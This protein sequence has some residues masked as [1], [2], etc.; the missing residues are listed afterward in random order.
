MNETRRRNVAGF[1]V[2]LLETNKMDSINFNSF[3]NLIKKKQSIENYNVVIDPYDI[4]Y[5]DAFT[6]LEIINCHFTGS[7]L[8]IKSEAGHSV[9]KLSLRNSFFE[10]ISFYDVEINNL[11]LYNLKASYIN[12]NS[13]TFKN[14]HVLNVQ[15]IDYDL[16][17]NNVKT[18]NNTEIQGCSFAKNGRLYIFKSDLNYCNFTENI[19]NDIFFEFSTFQ[20]RFDFYKNTLNR[21]SNRFLFLDCTFHK[22][23]FTAT[24]LSHSTYFNTCDFTGTSILHELE[25]YPMTTLTFNSCLFEKYVQFNYTSLTRLE[26]DNTKFNEVASFQDTEFETLSIE[27]TIFEK[28]GLFDNIKLKNIN[29]CNIRSLRSIKQQLQKADNAIDYSRFRSYELA[30]YYKELQWTWKNGKDKVI[31][32]ATKIVTGF[33]HSWR[34]ALA[35]TILAGLSW[36]SILYFTQYTGSFNIAEMNNYFSSAF[37]FFL[38]T[39]FSSPFRE[40]GEYFNLAIN[41]VPLILGK[42]FGNYIRDYT[43][44]CKN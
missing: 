8:I 44:C 5:V 20:N 33:D 34:R 37:K 9:E 35:F 2:G 28:A 32:G 41:W 22:T 19:F 17:I 43:R 23:N 27:R 7:D 40:K 38:I 26:I 42:I 18:Q 4:L 21:D 12:L 39:D 15:E 11:F 25:G 16:K 36:Y 6:N 29:D 13:C 10:G 24:T 3:L 31:L 1:F 30:A 14:L